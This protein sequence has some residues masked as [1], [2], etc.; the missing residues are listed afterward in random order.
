MTNKYWKRENK[1]THC[2]ECGTELL[3]HKI[4]FCT[5]RCGW[6]HNNK[7][8]RVVKLQPEVQNGQISQVEVKT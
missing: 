2:K 4:Y 8:N 6:V 7:K 1:L 5:S 3:P